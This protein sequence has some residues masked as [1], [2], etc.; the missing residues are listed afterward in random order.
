MHSYQYDAL[1]SFEDEKLVLANNV[2]KDMEKRCTN[3]TS[4]LK[5][6]S[7]VFGYAQNSQ[8]Q[9][10]SAYWENQI[11]LADSNVLL[12]ILIFLQNDL[13]GKDAYGM[14]KGGWALRTAWKI[15]QKIYN[16]IKDVYEQEIGPLNLPVF[17]DSLDEMPIPDDLENVLESPC[18]SKTSATTSQCNGYIPHSKSAI[19]NDKIR[20]PSSDS[21][22]QTYQSSMKKSVSFNS[23]LSKNERDGFWNRYNSIKSSV[24][25]TYLKSLTLFGSNEVKTDMDKETIT[26]LMT[27]VS[28]GYGLLQLGCSLL[29]PS[30]L[31]LTNFL[32]FNSDRNAGLTCLKFARTGQDMRAPLATLSLLWYHTIVRPFY[33]MDGTNVQAGAAAARQLIAE[34]EEKYGRSCFF[35][36]FRGRAHRVNGEIN[37]ALFSFQEAVNVTQQREMKLLASHEVGWCHLIRLDFTQA[38]PVFMYMKQTSRWSKP[39]YCYITVLCTGASL[40]PGADMPILSELK[41]C[42]KKVHKNNQLFEFLLKRAT[43]CPLQE[44]TLASINQVYWRLFIYEM[45]YLWNALASCS[46]ESIDAIIND[47]KTVKVGDKTE[48]PM[49]GLSLL[50]AGS[51]HSIKE[52]HEGAVTSFEKCLECRMDMQPDAPD[53]H[54]SAFAHYEYAVILMKDPETREEGRKHLQLI[55]QYYGFDFEQKLNVRVNNLLKQK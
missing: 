22:A 16:Q 10:L 44:I 32:G 23:N 4:W 55:N 40:E 14:F 38:T 31:K 43:Y 39:F 1:M 30:V 7:R 8:S 47:C 35:L 12:G 36:F 49:K 5:N 52:E 19:L 50:I 9:S 20:K 6:V 33:S 2:L 26:R 21:T 51:C 28:F 53:A 48:E 29:P 24:T 54:I 3:N 11:I 13:S 45:L 15:Y 46:S 17:S 27:A 34:S 37:E 18:V 41:E 25:F 42:I